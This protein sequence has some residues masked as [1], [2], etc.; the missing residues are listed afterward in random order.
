MGNDQIAGSEPTIAANDG[1]HSYGGNIFGF[2]DGDA[3]LAMIYP[4]F[5]GGWRVNIRLG[6]MPEQEIERPDEASARLAV[7][8]ALRQF[9]QNLR[10]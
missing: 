2:R 6:G 10:G 8:D 3:N 1:W 4:M 5:K 9:N 7:L